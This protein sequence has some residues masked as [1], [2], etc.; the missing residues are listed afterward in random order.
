MH[1]LNDEQKGMLAATVTYIIFGFSY[2]FSKMA[3]DITSPI[4]LLC[5]RFTLTFITL[6]ILVLTGIVKINLKGKP[7]MM[8]ILIGLIQ[9]CLYFVLENYGLQYTT[10]SFTGIFSSLNPVFTA[11]LG[12]LIL[13]E[14]P[15]GKQWLSILV[16]I[17]GVLIVSLDGSGGQNTV[18]G[19]ICLVSAYFLGSFYSL[20]IRR[21]SEKFTPF[22]LT[23]VMFSVAFVFFAVLAFVTYRGGT[24]VM[25]TSALSHIDF[26][27]AIAYLG[28]G[29]SVLA[30]FLA[31]YSLSKL[32]VA[33]STIFGNLSTVV[34]V[35]A[36]VFI[37][38]DKFTWVTALAFALI[39]CGIFGV[40]KFKSKE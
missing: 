1:K 35:L 8:P 3:M 37:M 12:A 31:N 22:E 15:N 13:R 9:P 39:L 32:P 20:M 6:N 26:L 2:L 30:Y 17:T 5:A 34:S 11:L 25:L 21:Y 7:L 24:V 33:R 16:S 4:I 14:R 18:L 29:S 27:I 10:T 28:I 38:G 19:C 36:G 40:N 23:Y